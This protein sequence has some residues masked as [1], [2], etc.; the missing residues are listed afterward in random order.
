MIRVKE[1]R[2]MRDGMAKGDTHSPEQK[3]SGWRWEANPAL[4]EEVPQSITA[5]E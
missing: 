3:T 1:Y 5:A 4:K 2:C